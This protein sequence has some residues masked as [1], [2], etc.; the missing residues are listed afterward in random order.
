MDENDILYAIMELTGDH[1]RSSHVDRNLVGVT[2]EIQE[3]WGSLTQLLILLLVS[4][5]VTVEQIGR[6]E[7]DRGYASVVV[8][9]IRI[10]M[11]GA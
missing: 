2:V 4:L 10:V 9:K 11:E 7:T 6:V 8:D 3:E 5:D 1:L